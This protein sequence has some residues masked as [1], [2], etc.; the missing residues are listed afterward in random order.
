MGLMTFQHKINLLIPTSGPIVR[1]AL[2]LNH[3]AEDHFIFVC[4]IGRDFYLSDIR[5]MDYGLRLFLFG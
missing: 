5:P 2:F 1:I 3:Q 4:K